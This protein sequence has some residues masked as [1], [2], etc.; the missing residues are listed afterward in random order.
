MFN[1]LNTN[2]PHQPH[3]AYEIELQVREMDKKMALMNSFYHNN[4]TGGENGI[5]RKTAKRIA[6][7]IAALF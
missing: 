5:V 7:L 2:Q 3:R 6:S 1:D 4:S